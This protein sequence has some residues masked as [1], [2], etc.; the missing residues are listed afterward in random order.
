MREQ[1]KVSI[2]LDASRAYHRGLYH[3]IARYVRL[4]DAWTLDAEPTEPG[5]RN[6]LLSLPQ[7]NGAILLVQ[8]RQQLDFLR[9]HGLPF[10]TMSSMLEEHRLPHVSND[11]DAIGRMA[12][13]HFLE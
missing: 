8:T 6:P 5:G 4:H 13:T 11:G 10:V 7:S 12:L 1:R 2:L 9:R 3:G